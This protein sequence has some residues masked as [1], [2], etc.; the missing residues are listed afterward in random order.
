[1]HFA[2]VQFHFAAFLSV[3][4][5]QR[6]I[7]TRISLG[8]EYCRG[9]CCQGREEGGDIKILHS[10]P[11]FDVQNL[12]KRMTLRIRMLMLMHILQAVEVL[13]SVSGPS[14]HFSLLFLEKACS[15]AINWK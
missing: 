10:L 12:N 15:F 9:E 8:N 1:M 14:D 7:K 5:L 13:F 11:S 6:E 4:S 3:L 2:K